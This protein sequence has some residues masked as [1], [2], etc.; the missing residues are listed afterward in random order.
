MPDEELKTA[1]QKP[2]DERLWAVAEGLRRGWTVEAINKISRIDKWFLRKIKTLITIEQKLDAARQ[3]SD[4]NESI[5]EL[6]QEAFIFG[7][8]SPSILSILGV[9]GKGEP[10]EF[11]ARVLQEVERQ[12]VMPVF[13]MVD[14]CAGEFESRTP[15]YYGTFEQES[16]MV[17]V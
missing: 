11:S 5:S 16:D 2:T 4:C 7:F 6:I 13:K 3:R 17:S 15:Y 14:T 8:P 1:I 10:N 12:K 9:D